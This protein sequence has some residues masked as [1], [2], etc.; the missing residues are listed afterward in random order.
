[1]DPSLADRSQLP[2]ASIKTITLKTSG[3]DLV[4]ED[5]PHIDDVVG[6][7]IVYAPNGD[8]YFRSQGIKYLTK[9]TT[10]DYLLVNLKLLMKEHVD[11]RGGATW[12]DDEDLMKYLRVK[13][14]QSNHKDITDLITNA[15]MAG[16]KDVWNSLPASGEDNTYQIKTIAVHEA[17]KDMQKYDYKKLASG[18]RVYDITLDVNF[19]LRDAE[20]NHL[21]YYAATY[22]DIEQLQA[23]MGCTSGNVGTLNIKPVGEASIEKV[24]IS[25][26]VVENVYVYYYTLPDGS[27]EYYTGRVIRD[28]GTPP[29]YLVRYYTSTEPPMQLT[30]E[31][32][33]NKKIKDSRNMN[34]FLQDI[35]FSLTEDELTSLTLD[36]IASEKFV[37]LP[38]KEY[39]SNIA[40]SRDEDGN[41]KTIFAVNYGKLLLVNTEFGKLFETEDSS[42]FRAISRTCRIKSLRCLRRRVDKPA[43]ATD[44]RVF[45]E[46][47][48]FTKLIAY[49]T[50][51]K[52]AGTLLANSHVID[53]LGII[54]TSSPDSELRELVGKIKEVDLHPAAGFANNGIRHFSLLDAD[55]AKLTDGYYQYGVE[56]EIEDGTRDYLQNLNKQLLEAKKLLEQ[57]YNICL[58]RV[59]GIGNY[60]SYSEAFTKRFI[61]LS[62]QQY[63]SIAADEKISGR[64]ESSLAGALDDRL[65]SAKHEPL[66]TTPE[67]TIA[68]THVHRY[69]I[70]A[71][72]NGTAHPVE[73]GQ[74][75]HK[76][77]NFRVLSGGSNGHMHVIPVVNSADN[78]PWALAI[79][80]YLSILNIVTLNEYTVDKILKM[81]N[82]LFDAVSPETGSPEGILSV[83]ALIDDLYTKIQTTVGAIADSASESAIVSSK[84]ALR[85]FKVEK[86]FDDLADSNIIRGT[87]YDYLDTEEDTSEFMEIRGSTYVNTVTRP[88]ESTSLPNDSLDNTALTF[89]TPAKI[90]L[91]GESIRLNSGGLDTLDMAV[92][93]VAIGMVI[94]QNQSYGKS[95]SSSDMLGRTLSDSTMFNNYATLSS[96]GSLQAAKSV[97]TSVGASADLSKKVAAL[98]HGLSKMVEQQGVLTAELELQDLGSLGA[99]SMPGHATI[100]RTVS[101]K[102]YLGEDSK[103]VSS[104]DSDPFNNDNQY[105]PKG[106]ET[107]Q[108][109]NPEPTPKEMLSSILSQGAVTNL[110]NTKTI[111]ASKN[112]VS[113]F[114]LSTKDNYITI[115][116]VTA[117]Q[118]KRLPNTLKTAFAEPS[119]KLSSR[120][121]IETADEKY[122][123]DEVETLAKIGEQSYFRM[124]YNLIRQVEVLIGYEET[125]KSTCSI[126]APIWLP[127]T[128]KIYNNAVGK[129][130]L[131]RTTEY[132][133]AAMGIN[134]S[135]AMQLPIFNEHF[136]MRPDSKL[137]SRGNI[138]ENSEQ[139]KKRSKVS[140]RKR[141]NSN[142][143]RGVSQRTRRGTSGPEHQRS[144]GLYSTSES[145]QNYRKK[146]KISKK[147]YSKGRIE[148]NQSPQNA[149]FEHWLN[150]IGDESAEAQTQEAG[151]T[152]STNQNSVNAN[153]RGGQRTGRQG[154]MSRRGSRNRGGSY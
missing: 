32:V 77:R 72:G 20:P 118:A 105:G 19:T 150:S 95:P 116:K 8:Y 96:P 71:N 117:Q 57:H 53:P 4:S 58:S 136:L 76:I 141:K 10:E 49:S 2:A 113:K 68:R 39:I 88:G 124:N 26:S 56:L 52:Q 12:T 127:M 97:L 34:S 5:N 65:L 138:R 14:I 55:I 137:A 27:R 106:C 87:G 60:N 84:S 9:T 15:T 121:Q 128:H 107:G 16:V 47:V 69:T 74:H 61:E 33:S 115:G 37:G 152:E 6:T 24:I 92:I 45:D 98:N 7:N 73:P 83:I 85:T 114:D 126:K 133:N 149:D 35:Q 147:G 94:P 50:E 123:S 103:F 132:N 139:R 99:V 104:S 135:N 122:L 44:W 119:E 67:S 22:L 59:Q 21:S 79:K 29:H 125:Q 102:N 145:T 23:D 3:G 108:D 131:C 18:D 66:P 28:S 146:T 75:V 110:F 91:G 43:A 51:K 153:D 13:I 48:E 38:S 78:S 80:K 129:T 63:P 1:M 86:W 111:S 130:L 46:Q 148:A 70:D 151:A 41:Y 64:T 100:S 30:K 81:S 101:S 90:S 109:I 42:L 31:T 142:S 17:I 11:I 89:M 62:R 40:P 120:F 93:E 144:V 134:S 112:M 82:M 140:K 36:R 143:G 25:G 154:R 54:S